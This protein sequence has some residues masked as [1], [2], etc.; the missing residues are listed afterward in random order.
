M[1][2]LGQA[3]W[4]SMGGKNGHIEEQRTH[5]HKQRRTACT[6]SEQWETPW[7]E[8]K[9][10]LHL[11]YRSM[12]SPV[13]GRSCQ[14]HQR[15]ICI[16]DCCTISSSQFFFKKLLLQYEKVRHVCVPVVI[17]AFL[18][19]LQLYML[20]LYYTWLHS[21][22]TPYVCTY[23]HCCAVREMYAVLVLE[24]GCR[25]ETFDISKQITV[26]LDIPYPACFALHRPPSPWFR[27]EKN[28][29]H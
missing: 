23:V 28:V 22:T 17:H 24:I 25:T 1:R 15:S 7:D 10:Y 4:I 21:S 11:C 8:K 6:S 3:C 27:T 29:P 16:L 2:A 5:T 12:L 9:V 18:C 13:P 14:V 19:I 26:T 20:L